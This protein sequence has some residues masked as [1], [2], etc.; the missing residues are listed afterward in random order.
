M[1]KYIR[2][3]RKGREIYLCPFNV[4]YSVYERK[5]VCVKKIKPMLLWPYLL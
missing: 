2:R 3:D 1:E 5:Y 4:T